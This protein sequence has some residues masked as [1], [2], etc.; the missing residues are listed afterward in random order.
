MLGHW[1]CHYKQNSKRFFDDKILSHPW[2][3][4]ATFQKDYKEIQK[5]YEASLLTM[6]EILN[7]LFNKNYSLRYW[8]ILIGPWLNA[9]ISIYY[10][11]KLLI[12]KS[13]K[14]KKAK[15]IRFKFKRED[16][17]PNSTQDFIARTSSDEWNYYF[18]LDIL[19]NSLNEKFKFKEINL[20]LKP[21]NKKKKYTR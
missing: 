17:I 16:Y 10:E 15:I 14:I 21:D 4:F 19:Q 6:Q 3:K 1:C 18:F 7:E 5:I 13:K 9:I 20:F 8:R 12:N 2:D 11:K